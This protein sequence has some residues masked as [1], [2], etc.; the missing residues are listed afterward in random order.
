[1]KST[2]SQKRDQHQYLLLT[3]PIHHQKKGYEN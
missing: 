1:L 3:V 2:V